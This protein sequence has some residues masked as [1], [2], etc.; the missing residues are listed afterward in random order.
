[1][2]A[3]A[4]PEPPGPVE[5]RGDADPRVRRR[6]PARALLVA[7][8]LLGV[9]WSAFAWVEPTNFGGFDE[10][11]I[12]D[13]TS[14][15]TVGFPYANRPLVFTWAVPGALLLPHTLSGYFLLHTGYLFASGLALMALCRRL[16]PAERWFP[17][18]SAA[19][20]VSWA[21]L[22]L[23]RVNAIN[24]LFY[25]GVAFGTL[26]AIVLFQE[27]W[28]RRSRTLLG[29]AAAIGFVA[30]R[31]YEAVLALLLLGPPLLL[32]LERGARRARL[33]WL[34]PW[35]IV[36]AGA[37]LLAA[38]PALWPDPIGSYQIS[39]L[40]LDAHP[41]RWTA[42]AVQQLAYHLLPLVAWPAGVAPLPPSLAVL[43]VMAMMVG[44]ASRPGG[45]GTAS[46]RLLVRLAGVGLAFAGLGVAVLSLSSSIRGPDRVQGFSGPGVALL[47]GAL[48]SMP[49]AAW[50]RRGVLV[51][52][53]LASW[54][55]AA[56]TARTLALQRRWD[57]SSAYALQA[58]VLRQILDVA[59]DVEPNTLFVL[60]DDAA[61]FP[62]TFT[63]RHAVRYLYEG[64]ALGHVWAGHDLFYP[65]RFTPDAVVIE[66]WPRNRD[67][68]DAPPTRHAYDEIVIVRVDGAGR[69]SVERGWPER[70]P[71]PAQ[72]SRYAPLD[73]LVPAPLGNP[74]AAI[75]AHAP[76]PDAGAPPRR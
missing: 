50:P 16:A 53:A 51:T 5:Q 70:L 69:V 43:G 23:H 3:P 38:A 55:V 74:R 61:A 31:S 47:L 30:A 52:A 60:L 37:A 42:R 2:I 11:F 71:R 19:F 25:S 76:G 9:L 32:A 75:L 72:S 29:V 28:R 58:G 4:T 41:A 62:A 18:L 40:G 63:F 64:R 7:L 49:A 20:L 66:P 48:A 17:V 56:G 35:E 73:R 57:G 14:R 65:T 15:G 46:L 39:G 54:V 27:S 21:P 59:P 67:A 12:V 68:W 13:L 26:L 24:N 34:A 6:R 33:A 8:G 36:M 45:E 44:A 10:W 1:M 22:D